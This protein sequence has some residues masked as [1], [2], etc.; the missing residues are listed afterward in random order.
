MTLHVLHADNGYTYLTDSIAVGDRKLQKGQSMS[1]YYNGLNGTPR[2]QWWGKGAEAMGV[3]GAVSERQMIALYGEGIH[4]DADEIMQREADKGASAEQVLAAAKIGRTFDQL[5]MDRA[6]VFEAIDA[7][8]AAE[9]KTK[10]AALNV[11]EVRAVRLKEARKEWISQGRDPRVSKTELGRWL[12]RLE[13]AQKQPVAGYDLVFTPQKSV[14][15]VWGLGNE[16]QQE[17]I[18]Q[19]HERA[20]EQALT[21]VEQEA[22]FS[23]MGAQGVIAVEGAGLSVARYLHWD[24]RAGDPNLHTHAVV[25]N[26]V[27]CPIDGK[28][29]ALDGRA[30]HQITTAAS[31]Y[32]NQALV[33]NMRE[34]G[35]D[36][37]A[38]ES[39]SGRAPIYE[40]KGVP[41][42]LLDRFSRRNDIETRVDE[43]AAEYRK[44]HLREPSQKT[45]YALFQQA[46]LET[47][48]EKGAPKSLE[49]MRQEWRETALSVV[50]ERT[51]DSAL[52]DVQN[53]RVKAPAIDY[54]EVAEEVVERLEERFNT[55]SKINVVSATAQLMSAYDVGDIDQQHAMIETVSNIV[56]NDHCIQFGSGQ[57]FNDAGLIYT[58][59]NSLFHQ[60]RRERYVSERTIWRENS[61]LDAAHAPLESV[62]PRERINQAISR[63][64]AVEGREFNEGQ[65]EW[66]REILG[67]GNQLAVAIG[68]AGTGKTTAMK[69]VAEAWEPYGNVLALGTSAAAAD[70]LGKDLGVQAYTIA[71][72]LTRHRHGVATGISADTLVIVDEAGMA[73][74]K[75]LYE[76]NEIACKAGAR[77]RLIGDPKQLSAVD[78]G[79][80]LS[81]LA[82]ITK[83]PQLAEVVRF[84]TE[85]EAANSLD[86]R[87]GKFESLEFFMKHGRA[88]EGTHE[89]HLENVFK[90]WSNDRAEGYNSLMIATRRV[91]V[92]A[93]NEA[94]QQAR[95]EAGE[96]NTTATT[97]A[98]EGVS[99]Y[100]GD[101][102]V[103]RK[104]EGTI[105]LN[106]GEADGRR[107]Y[108]GDLWRVERINEDGSLQAVHVANGGRVDMPAAYV[109][110]ST[111]LGYAT[112][113]HRSQGLTVDCAHMLIDENTSREL[114]Y[115]GLTRGK[116]ENHAYIVTESMNTR[117]DVEHPTA[118]TAPPS[119]D[120]VWAN[121]MSRSSADKSALDQITDGLEPEATLQQRYNYV[122]G[123]LIEGAMNKALPEFVV[124]AAE[125][126]EEV[127]ARVKAL[128]SRALNAGVALPQEGE[129][130]EQWLR[131]GFA[132]IPDRP[133]TIG[134]LPSTVAEGYEQLHEWAV[135]A[136][137][138][139][140]TEKAVTQVRRNE[141]GAEFVYRKL[142]NAA[143]STLTSARAEL[144]AR[145]EAVEAN[146]A[147]W[148]K[149]ASALEHGNAH[150]Q[151]LRA[152]APTMKAAGMIKAIQAKEKQLETARDSQRPRLMSERDHLISVAPSREQWQ[153]IIERAEGV[154]S[155][156][157]QL[158]AA[159]RKGQQA[160]VTRGREAMKDARRIKTALA[161]IDKELAVRQ[162]DGISVSENSQE[163]QDY[164]P[165]VATETTAERIE[166]AQR[167]A[168]ARYTPRQAAQWIAEAMSPATAVSEIVERIEHQ[169]AT[170]EVAAAATGYRAAPKQ[171]ELAQLERRREQLQQQLAT[172]EKAAATNDDQRVLKAQVA[173]AAQLETKLTAAEA[174][175]VLKQQRAEHAAENLPPK[176]GRLA[177]S[178][179]RQQWEDNARRVQE[180]EK[181]ARA[182][183][184]RIRTERAELYKQLPPREKW[185][186]I[187]TENNTTAHSTQAAS[188]RNELAQV[189]AELAQ[190]QTT[191][192]ATPTPQQQPPQPA[193]E[194]V[195]QPE[196]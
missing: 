8:I 152:W 39:H 70:V 128:M 74:T 62:V 125:L 162:R 161:N 5:V 11:H 102:I 182:E 193:P 79:G 6:P 153:K 35:Y 120:T 60:S 84:A 92:A 24:N 124:E 139:L 61:L 67:S 59:G 58:Q 188:L 157:A 154:R 66:V 156:V 155:E 168:D 10:G 173:K 40:V 95:M 75:D 159:E 178:T 108:N 20:V 137:E 45:M 52:N 88:H 3:E 77:V 81:T 19:A 99:V 192:S 163:W 194:N 23:R 170:A 131:N 50:D 96:L 126:D 86:V 100:V 135:N 169:A 181:Q 32:Y 12:G 146:R 1:N 105:K 167:A 165:K 180:S 196:M 63:V 54:S 115:V 185:Q 65:R 151:L 76:L 26:K 37:E 143:D 93:L 71:N 104:N 85:G 73:S 176:P 83:A 187:L 97:T 33:Q 56:L 174:E 43:L 110:E 68:A 149:H 144:A 90:A 183:V 171:S 107:I 112:T 164:V 138:Q 166:A 36:F 179:K 89:E 48:G 191:A 53:Q 172:V 140:Q 103:S 41:Q 21:F 34:L 186:S 98:R 132:D 15:V 142:N 118:D 55:F 127:D 114:A 64:E 189:N 27:L 109:S 25:S 94:A 141:T 184:Q 111:E 69:A 28:W 116:L 29:R 158:V 78:S 150:R 123:V 51:L 177:S 87:A 82:N 121:V 46:T 190:R 91:D 17:A 18:L 122:R 195:Q 119:M 117:G 9:E 136:R 22:A 14:S 4:P 72:I 42:E 133:R 129:N 7:R 147:M 160:C 47:R 44:K 134:V 57:D 106:G 113:V 145:L 130:V 16:Q 49:E 2:G 148:F 101:V 30:M 31:N 80:M 38:H 13:R 175:A